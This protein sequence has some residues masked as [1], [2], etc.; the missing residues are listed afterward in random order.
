[1]NITFTLAM[2]AS[3]CANIGYDV[4]MFMAQQLLSARACFQLFYECYNENSKLLNLSDFNDLVCQKMSQRNLTYINV[5]VCYCT[6]LYLAIEMFTFSYQHLIFNTIMLALCV[7]V[8]L[9]SL[10]YIFDNLSRV[11][12][13]LI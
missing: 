3:I 7:I 1:M 8:L 11:F 5:I 2:I 6:L 13:K 4:G 12:N 10:Y 9:N